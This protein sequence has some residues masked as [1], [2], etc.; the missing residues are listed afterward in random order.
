MNFQ[1]TR[2][3]ADPTDESSLLIIEGEVFIIDTDKIEFVKN[4]PHVRK[5]KKVWSVNDDDGIKMLYTTDTQYREK[6]YLDLLFDYVPQNIGA[7]I[8]RNGN[9]YDYRVNNIRYILSELNHLEDEITNNYHYTINDMVRYHVPKYGISAK[10]IM[11][12]IWNVTDTNG[13][14][15]LLMYCKENTFTKI[16]VESMEK[17][18]EFHEKYGSSWFYHEISGYI[19]GHMGVKCINLH[20][21]LTDFYGQKNKK[22]AISNY[23]VD[24][25]NQDKLDNRMENLRIT[26]QSE[27]NRNRG[28]VGRHQNAKE[29]PEE[30]N[31]IIFPKYVYYSAENYS[32]KKGGP[33]VAKDARKKSAVSSSEEKRSES[34]VATAIEDIPEY[35]S[36]FREYFNFE[37]KTPD[38]KRIRRSSSKSMQVPILKKLEQARFISEYF[39]AHGEPPTKEMIDAV[40]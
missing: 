37:A 26:T 38:G 2:N 30:L 32:A 28:K 1:I 24:H 8:F 4:P 14:T 34:A 19:Q 36:G 7:F 40:I 16:S 3:P 33:T 25:I 9:T 23:S 20:Q 6:S 21:Y 31:G 5:T 29:L 22:N 39:Q 27:Q 35:Q 18:N 13:N 11:N 15:F 17:L 10:Q 12:P